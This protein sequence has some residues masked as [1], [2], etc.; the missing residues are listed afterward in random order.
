MPVKNAL[1]IW[2]VVVLE[3]ESTIYWLV[4][5]LEFQHWLFMND[6]TVYISHRF[7]HDFDPSMSLQHWFIYDLDHCLNL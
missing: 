1:K 6:T 4:P 7:V 3:L 5:G 2:R